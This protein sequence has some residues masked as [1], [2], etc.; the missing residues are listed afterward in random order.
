MNPEIDPQNP[1]TKF[2]LENK[3]G[4]ALMT[5]LIGCPC[6]GTDPKC[7]GFVKIRAV[8]LSTTVP[9]AEAEKIP[10]LT[11]IPMIFENEEQAKMFARSIG[12]KNIVRA[13]L[14]A[15]LTKVTVGDA[16]ALDSAV[17]TKE[18]ILSPYQ[19]IRL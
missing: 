4:Q 1:L 13:C 2:M 8:P 3:Q 18:P 14:F 9:G 6:N 15:S 11:N 10:T 16:A 5:W 19:S 17:N 7:D 12:A